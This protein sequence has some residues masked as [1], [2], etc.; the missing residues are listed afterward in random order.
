MKQVIQPVQIL[1]DNRA[2]QSHLLT[3][4]FNTRLIDREYTTRVGFGGI[5]GR[6]LHQDKSD[7]RY[8]K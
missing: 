1:Y 3:H 4:C 8:Q 6:K 5:D 7:R 2:I